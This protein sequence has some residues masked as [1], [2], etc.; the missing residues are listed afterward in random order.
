MVA[1]NARQIVPVAA[2]AREVAAAVSMPAA[3]FTHV[4]A[5]PV[6]TAAAKQ[7]NATGKAAT[8]DRNASTRTSQ[9]C[10]PLFTKA[11]GRI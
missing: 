7:E 1:V 10:N 6:K 5:T 9:R 11:T 2:V 4:L 8:L 3:V